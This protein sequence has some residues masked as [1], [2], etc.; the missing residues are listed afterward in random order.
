MVLFYRNQKLRKYL[1]HLV[2]ILT[3]SYQISWCGKIIQLPQSSLQE[4]MG[5]VTTVSSLLEQDPVKK[6]HST[7]TQYLNKLTRSKTQTGST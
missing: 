4:T 7:D 6:K 3:S 2:Y 5:L 1:F